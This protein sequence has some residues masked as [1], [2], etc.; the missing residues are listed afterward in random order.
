MVDKGYRELCIDAEFKTLI[1]PL[2][3]DEYAQLEANLV[4]DG[5]RDPIIVWNDVIVDGHNRYEICNRLHIPYVVQ[6]IAFESREDAIVWICNNQLGRRNI[7]E[8]T[9]KYLIGRQYEAEKVVGFH[10]NTDGHNQYTRSDDYDEIGDP[11]EM[12]GSE[13]RESSRRTA[14]RLGKKYHLSSGAVQKYGKYSAALDTIADK[15]PELVPQILSG[16][17]KISH[18]NLVA[19]SMMEAEEVQ[20]LSKKVGHGAAPFI[21]YSESRKEFTDEPAQKPGPKP[22]ELPVIKI[23]PAF[24][25]DAEVTGLT[26]TIPSW[27]S[28]IDRIKAA[29][30]LHAVS[31]SAKRRLEDALLS[32]QG[33]AQEMIRAMKEDS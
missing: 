8:E 18:D 13:R 7:T 17:Y 16:N 28:S 22:P 20:K 27:T 9:R 30:D 12:S 3:R 5:C 6:E 4:L 25:P 15:A 29:A 26:L 32:L 24:D 23:M 10:R 2:R 11:R 31:P 21:R 33:K 1:R 19:M 14:N